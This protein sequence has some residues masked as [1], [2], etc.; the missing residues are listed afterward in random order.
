MTFG[1]KDTAVKG[2]LFIFFLMLIY[3]KA[4]RKKCRPF[5]NL[6]TLIGFLFHEKHLENFDETWGWSTH[7]SVVESILSS[8]AHSICARI[9]YSPLERVCHIFYRLEHKRLFV[10]PIV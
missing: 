2:D 10:H 9:L 1:R 8:I 7:V 4:S 3:L 5:F 6:S